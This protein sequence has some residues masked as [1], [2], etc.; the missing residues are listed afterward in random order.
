MVVDFSFKRSPRY[1]VATLRGEVPWTE[2]SLREA[3]RELG[4]WAKR[5]R[6][7]TGKW[8]ISSPSSKYWEA[9]LEI[10]GV[11]RGE[12]RIHVK[13]LPA[14][15][16]ATLTFDPDLVSPRVIYHGLI[17]WLKWRRKAKEIKSAGLTREIYSTD[18][19][20]DPKAWSRATV[21]YVVRR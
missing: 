16:V 19:W 1:R 3:F 4:A 7:R 10:K 2:R 9:C 5:H 8:I 15:T 6:M 13:V 14:T 12:G 20:S 17:D 21:E 18:P 11:A